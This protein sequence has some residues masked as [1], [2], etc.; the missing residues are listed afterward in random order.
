MRVSKYTYF[1][2]GFPSPEETLAVNWL[3]QGIA[4]MDHEMYAVLSS[5]GDFDETCLD[6]HAIAAL[7]DAGIAVECDVDERAVVEAWYADLR[8]YRKTFRAIIL[9]TY[10]CNFA[11]PY[12]VER[13]IGSAASMTTEVETG[14]CEWMQGCIEQQGAEKLWVNFYGGEPL[15]ALP[16]LE[17]IAGTMGRYAADHGIEFS[18][19]VTTNGSLLSAQTARRLPRGTLGKVCTS[20]GENLLQRPRRSGAVTTPRD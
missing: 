2:Q 14:V 6:A 15:L 13:G 12:C 11:C 8:E 7:G 1:L 20:L 3:T 10:D 5:G 17:R 4:V 18:G 19:S 9:P 16:G